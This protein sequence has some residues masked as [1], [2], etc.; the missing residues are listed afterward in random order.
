MSAGAVGS[1]FK[2]IPM[3]LRRDFAAELKA[4]ADQLASDIRAAAPTESG[5]L[6]S[7]V[8]VQRGKDTLELLVLAG[9]PSTTKEVRKGSG[10]SYD[11]A[12][13]IEFGTTKM[14]AQ[15]FF[16]STYRLQR[17]A[18]RNKIYEAAARSVLSA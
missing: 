7:S 8:R 11:Y 4:I 1:W 10:V 17:D 14:E 9:G 3:R 6:Q 16:Y 15:P 18:V 2:Q 12:L 5:K 13:G